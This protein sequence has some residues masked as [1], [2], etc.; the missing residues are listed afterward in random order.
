M[1][2]NC[3]SGCEGLRVMAIETNL[4]WCF[5]STLKWS[6]ILNR[7]A[8]KKDGTMVFVHKYNVISVNCS[9]INSYHMATPGR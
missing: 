4:P 8:S 2:R 3:R 9:S 7:N 5:S 1:A 6:F